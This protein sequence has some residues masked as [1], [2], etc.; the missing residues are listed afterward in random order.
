M[1]R[2]TIYPSKELRKK[3]EERAKQERRSLNNL[4][5]LILEKDVKKK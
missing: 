1:E 2:I 3:L 4:I 5:I